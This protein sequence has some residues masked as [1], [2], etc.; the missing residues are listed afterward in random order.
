MKH[1][2]IFTDNQ[3]DNITYFRTEIA[4]LVTMTIDDLPYLKKQEFANYSG[5]YI[6]IGD[7]KR[8]VG[9]ACSC[10]IST[11]LSDHLY[12]GKKDWVQS[13]L[14]FC[15]T[16]G[17]MS[18]SEADYLEKKLIAEFKERSEYALD[19][20]TAGNSSHI[21]QLTK[22]MSDSLYYNVLTIVEDIANIDIFGNMDASEDVISNEVSTSGSFDIIFNGTTISHNSASGVYKKFMINLLND[23]KYSTVLRSSIVDDSPTAKYILGTKMASYNSRPNATKLEEHVWLYTNLTRKQILGKICAIAEELGIELQVTGW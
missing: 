12:Q 20:A 16:D 7:N 14:F 9:Q 6:L 23:T 18:K 2:Y 3:K 11:R 4:Y 13:I 8:Y 19:N 21:D 15:R 17:K 10:S 5:I 1:I 22:A